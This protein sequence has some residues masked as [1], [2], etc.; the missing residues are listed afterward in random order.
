[1]KDATNMLT[2]QMAIKLLKSL[3]LKCE[4]GNLYEFRVCPDC[5]GIGFNAKTYVNCERCGGYGILKYCPQQC[6]KN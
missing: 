3:K 1:M 6:K 5:G 4:C 2:G